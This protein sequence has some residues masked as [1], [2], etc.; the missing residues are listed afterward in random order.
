MKF[1]S[2][3]P[4]LPVRDVG[5]ALA[6]FEALGFQHAWSFDDVFAC[7]FGGTEIEL[8][9]RRSDEPPPVTLYLKVDDADAFFTDFS[10]HAEVL[11]PIHD[12]PWGMREFEVRIIDGH[13]LR[14]GHG[15]P[16]SEDRRTIA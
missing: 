15:V 3:T 2:C 7:V 16:G 10:D 14:V 13:V 9:L 12:T 11:Q 8:Y 5:A 4:E 6:A 1:E